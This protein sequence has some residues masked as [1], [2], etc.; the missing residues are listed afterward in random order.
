[1]K[2]WGRPLQCLAT[3]HKAG[4]SGAEVVEMAFVLPLLLA[5]LI[6]IIRR[7]R[8]SQSR[9]AWHD[10]RVVPKRLHRERLNH[11]RRCFVSRRILPKHSESR[12]IHAT[13]HQRHK[14]EWD[15]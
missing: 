14:R 1:M 10:L 11:R 4:E 3:R 12:W 2:T 7:Q 6:G 5:L 9:P 13:F 15:D 8:Q